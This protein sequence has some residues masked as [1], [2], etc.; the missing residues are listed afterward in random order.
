MMLY[1]D[2]SALVKR[3]VAEVGS[4]EVNRWITQA[5]QASTSLLARPEVAAAICRAARLD[6]ITQLESRKALELFRVEWESLGR[7]P[8]NEATARRADDLA[9]NHDLRGYD[10]MHLASALLYQ[11]ALGLP[12]VF[13]TYDRTLWQAAREENL[14]LLPENQP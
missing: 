10:A 11:H 7:L 12:L 5:Q 9:C 13:V 6:L 8:V 4:Q 14:L 2:S 3:Y 1:L